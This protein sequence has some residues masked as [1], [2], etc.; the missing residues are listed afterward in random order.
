MKTVKHLTNAGILLLSHLMIVNNALAINNYDDEPYYRDADTQ[1]QNAAL[2]E[3]ELAQILAPIA[4]YPD[5]LLTHIIIASTYPLELVQAQRWRERNSHLDAASAVELAEKQGWDPSVTALVAFDSVLERLNDDLQ[6]TQAL[7]EAFLEDE[8]RVLDSIQALRLQAERA[9]SLNKLENLRVT[10]VNRQIIIEPVR[11]EIIYVPYY[12]TRVVYGN[13]HWRKHPPIYW[14]HSPHVSVHFPGRVSGHISWNAGV[15]ISFNYFFGAIN[16]RNRHVVV[17]HYNNTRHYRTYN[18]IATSHGAKRWQHNPVHRRGVAY[19]SENVKTRFYN[20][21]QI[22]HYA[23]P[24]KQYKRERFALNKN[25]ERRDYS[26]YKK[27][28]KASIDRH[29]KSK[30][31]KGQAQ[32]QQQRVSQR[33]TYRQRD[34]LQQKPSSERPQNKQVRQ[35]RVKEKRADNGERKSHKQGEKRI[36]RPVNHSVKREKKRER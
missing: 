2:S 17:T 3:A 10:K 19:R 22:R 12:D 24:Q 8:E 29:Y 27:G 18:R 16:W 30:H 7:G 32:L 31:N 25:A 4:L 21:K 11:K 26:D 14:A 6:W 5:S 34:T 15:N 28:N 36:N 1:Y 23:E 9:N 35:Q 13:W 20:N 33:D